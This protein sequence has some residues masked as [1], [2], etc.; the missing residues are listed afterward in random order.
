MDELGEETR[1]VRRQPREDSVQ[2]REGEKRGRWGEEE[3]RREER[4][5]WNE[6]EGE[7][8]DGRDEWN[9]IERD[10]GGEVWDAGECT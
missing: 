2:E 4:S 5:E 10:E 1:S 3:W 7:V 8:R 9:E 6:R